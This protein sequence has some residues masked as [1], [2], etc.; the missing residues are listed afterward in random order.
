MQ[1]YNIGR[2]IGSYCA[3]EI[4]GRSINLKDAILSHR[5]QDEL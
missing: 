2:N 4:I 5:A 3:I 1:C